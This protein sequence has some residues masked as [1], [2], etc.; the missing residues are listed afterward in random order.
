MGGAWAEAAVARGARVGAPAPHPPPPA[1]TAGRGRGAAGRAGRAVAVT[2]ALAPG[3]SRAL[4]AGAAARHDEL[5]QAAL[6]SLAA[7]VDVI[8]LAQ[9]SM[10]RA[11]AGAD[12]VDADGRRVPVL[13][14]PRLGVERLSEVARSQS[15]ESRR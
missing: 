5:V 9:A 15:Q 4:K 3:A 13:T 7:R 10:A 12:S 14:S 6:R 1:P 11:L 8:V 2:A